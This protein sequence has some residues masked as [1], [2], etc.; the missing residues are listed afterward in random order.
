MALKKKATKEEVQEQEQEQEKVVYTCKVIRATQF[1]DAS[2][3]FDLS[4]NGITIFGM[5]YREYVN[6]EG[7]E[8]FMINFPS[9]K[10][11]GKYSDKYFNHVWFPISA[12][13]KADIQ[14]QIVHILNEV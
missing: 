4:V 14:N 2:A 5:V 12:E 9:R 13:L 6:K 7:K 8:G 10:G 3:G 11:T 1:D